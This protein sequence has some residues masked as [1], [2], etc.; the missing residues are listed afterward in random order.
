V[1]VLPNIEVMPIIS[2]SR[3]PIR[4][5]PHEL[6]SGRGRTGTATSLNRLLRAPRFHDDFG[7]FQ[8]RLIIWASLSPSR[9]PLCARREFSSSRKNCCFSFLPRCLNRHCSSRSRLAAFK[10]Q[11]PVLTPISDTEISL[12][13]MQTPYLRPSGHHS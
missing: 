9:S 12:S 10:R 11:D 4:H 3:S 5:S 13:S 1:A 6:P 7:E 2:S 8:Y